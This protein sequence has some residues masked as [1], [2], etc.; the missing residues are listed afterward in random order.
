MRKISEAQAIAHM[1]EVIEHVAAHG[2]RVMVARRGRA[3]VAVVPARQLAELDAF[4]RERAKRAK[5]DFDFDA[6][7]TRIQRGAD[8]ALSEEEATRIAV[9]EVKA[10]RR[11]RATRTKRAPSKAK[12]ATSKKRR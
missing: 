7:W 3:L 2:E 5:A 8:P 9:D 6:L 12:R 11:E 4:E 10:V 1:D